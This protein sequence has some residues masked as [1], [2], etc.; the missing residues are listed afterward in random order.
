[1]FKKNIL[2]V[3]HFYKK[4]GNLM[5]SRHNL[6]ISVQNRSGLEYRNTLK[7]KTLF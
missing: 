3:I 4:R 2:R 5:L 1:M 7:L 6:F